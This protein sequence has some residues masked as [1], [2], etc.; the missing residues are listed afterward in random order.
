MRETG[1]TTQLFALRTS[2]SS[3][4][5]ESKLNRYGTYSLTGP[6]TSFSI[7]FCLFAHEGVGSMGA[8]DRTIGGSRRAGDLRQGRE[9]VHHVHNFVAHPSGRD[10]GGP[11]DDKWRT[12]APFEGGVIVRP[13]GTRKAAPRPPQLRSIV[14]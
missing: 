8:I 3:W 1:T 9:N 10:F 4:G 14:A 12:D 13:P 2:V 6:H 11:A 5:S 7:G